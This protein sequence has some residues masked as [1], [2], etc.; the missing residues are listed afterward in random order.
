MI[1]RRH[2]DRGKAALEKLDIEL[3][4]VLS[5][6]DASDVKSHACE[7][8]DETE[9][10]VVVGD[11]DV[12]SDLVF[13]DIDCGNRYNHLRTVGKLTQHLYL[14]VRLKSRKN[15][16]GVVIVEKL[17]SELQVKLIVKLRY[18]LFNMLGLHTDILVV[19]KTYSHC[20]VN[21][22]YRLFRSL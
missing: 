22:P 18:S 2:A 9:H 21:L 13:L 12:S 1:I 4:G 3:T 5:Y 20:P 11:P 14:A 15:A 10:L 8:V 17:A 16:G 19:V 7:S 6:H